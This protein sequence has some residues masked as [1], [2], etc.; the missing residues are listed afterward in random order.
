L[1]GASTSPNIEP[2]N[3]LL[4]TA[5]YFIGRD[6][7]KWRTG[8]RTYGKIEYSEVYPRTDLV[9][10][11][12]Q[13]RLE[14]D[15]IVAPG[16]DPKEIRL[17]FH[18]PGPLSIAKDGAVRVATREGP[19]EL[20]RP[21]IYQLDHGKRIPINGHFGLRN[22]KNTIGIQV[23][24]Y[25]HQK[26]LIIDPVL[27]YS[28]YLGG[29]GSDYDSGVVVDSQ[30]DAYIAGQTTS[31]NFPSPNG[32]A[33]SGNSNGVAFVSELNPTGTALLYSTYLGGTGGDWGADV[34]LDPSGNVY[35]TGST[36]SNDFPIINAVQS[37]LL[38]PNGNAFV[39]RFDTTQPGTAS[40]VYSTYL[41]GG[42]NPSTSLGEVGLGIA[43][44]ANGLA[45][46]TGQTASDSSLAPFPTTNNAVQSSLASVNGNAFLTVLDTTNGGPLSLIYSTYLGGASDGFG[47]YGLGITVDS[48]GNAYLTGQ[49]TSGGS[50]P[51]PTT[52]GAYQTSLNS[53]YGNVFVTEISTAQTS[54]GCLV[55]STYLGG[56]SAIIVGDVA[57]GIGLDSNK[58]IYVGG[59]TTSADFPVTAGAYQTMNS[60]AGKA[61]VAAFDPTQTG[62]NSLIYSTLLGGTNGGEGEVVNALVVDGTGDAFVAGSTSSS[63]F[64]TTSGALQIT[65]KNSSWDAFL[66]EINPTGTGLLYSTYFGGS[67]AD[68]DLGNGV[69]IDW[70]G[71]PYLAG[72]TCSTDLP[73]YPSNAYQ[74]SLAGAYNTFVAKLAF[75]PTPGIK[76]TVSPVPNSSGWNNSAVTVSFVCMPGGAPLQSCS[77]PVVISTEGANQVASGTVVDSVNATATATDAVNLDITP[78]VI[79][80]SS[81]A[82]GATVT[83]TSLTVSGTITDALSGANGLTCNGLP[84][85]ITGS[86][87]SCALTVSSAVNSITLVG[88]DLAGNMATAAISVSLVIPGGAALTGN[89]NAARQEHTATLLTN[90]TVLIAGGT[91]AN[92]V[93]QA[94]AELYN[95]GTGTFAATGSMTVPRINHTATLLNDG[96]VLITGGYDSNGIPLNSA[97]IY[98]PATAAFT[99]VA[100]MSTGRASHTATLLSDGTVLIAGGYDINFNALASAEL[101]DPA[102][103]T[104]TG[105]GN[106]ITGRVSHT[107]TLLNNG[108]VLLAGGEDSNFNALAAAELY[109]PSSRSFTATGALN[110]GRDLHTAT[111]L[112]N[113]MV[114]I[115][116]GQDTNYSLIA[117]AEVFDSG[118][119]TFT[120]AGSMVTPR[121][122][123]TAT[124]LG[125]GTVLVAGGTASNTSLASS[126]LY[127][128]IAQ[129][130][131]A[132]GALNTA[133]TNHSATLLN[134]GTLLLVGGF[135]S[136]G[137]F[138]PVLTSAEVYQPTSLAPTNLVSI[139]I[140]P[141]TPSIPAGTAQLLAATGTFSDNSTEVLSSAIWS[142]SDNTV[143]AVTNDWS[144]RGTAIGIAP[145]TTTVSACTGSICGSTTLTI[146]AAQL[147][148]TGL[149]PA[150]GDIGA[151]VII[152]GTG[153]GATQGSSTVTFSG[154][155]ATVSMWS[156]TGIVV[157]V[158]A[159]ATTGNV[160]VNVGGT[161]SNGVLFTVSSGPV[162]T[163]LSPTEGFA[164][165]TVSISGAN[166]GAGQGGSVVTFNGLPAA[167]GSWSS[168]TI[169]V[170][171]PSGATTGNLVVTVS[172]ATS[173][174]VL[175]TVPAIAELSP[176]SG[177]V[178]TLVTIGGSGFG[179]TQGSGSVSINSTPM[180]VLSW[181]DS[182]IVAS[183]ANG[184][185]SGAVSVQQGSMVIPGPTFTISSA[186]PYNAL[187]Q[188]SLLV[189]QSRTVPIMDSR[190][191]PV[192]GLQWRT[193]NPAIVS[194]STDNPPLLTGVA[195]GSATVYAGVV[196]ISVTVYAGSSLPNGTVLWSLPVSGS[197][198]SVVPAVPSSSGADVFV[199]ASDAEIL[200]AVT[201]DGTVAWQT[202]TNAE[203]VIPDFSGNG[204]LYHWGNYCGANCLTHTVGKLDP[205]THQES[206]LYTFSTEMDPQW[207]NLG[208][209]PTPVYTDRLGTEAVIPDTGGNLFIE[210]I[211]KVVVFNPT[212]Q[213]VASIPLET[214]TV[215][216][217]P[218][219]VFA[220]SNDNPACPADTAVTLSPVEGKMIVAGDGN[221]YVPYLYTDAANNTKLMLLRVSPDGSYAKILLNSY[222]SNLP[223][224]L[225]EAQSHA[226]TSPSP[227]SVITNADQGVAVFSPAAEQNGNM[228]NGQITYVSGDAI[229]A[230]I[231]LP[232]DPF[233]NGSYAFWPQLQRED[234]SYIGTIGE[235]FTGGQCSY[236]DFTCY[237]GVQE[238]LNDNT[239]TLAAVGPGGIVWEQQFSSPVLPLYATSDGGAIVTST[240]A[241]PAPETQ[242]NLPTQLGTL[243]TLDQNGNV[244]LQTPDTGA[245][246]SWT[247]NWYVDP[248][249]TVSAV[250]EPGLELSGFGAVAQGNLSKNSRTIGEIPLRVHKV[251]EANVNSS[252][253][254]KRLQSAVSFWAAQA[255]AISWDGSIDQV[256][257]CPPTD[258]NCLEN[259]PDSIYEVSTQSA[260]QNYVL[261]RF[262]HAT[263]IDV[264]FTLDLGTLSNEAATI[265][266]PSGSPFFSNVVVVQ[267]NADD[268][269]PHEFGHVFQL[270]HLGVNPFVSDRLM[271]GPTSPFSFFWIFTSCNPATSRAITADEVNT[272]RKNALTLVPKQ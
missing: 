24:Q 51:F 7:S 205:V 152:A 96:T 266:N 213:Q 269:L 200:S 224:W 258:S 268:V 98:N 180:Q 103:G 17:H 89:L 62:S 6:R 252:I 179:A 35:V 26:P 131:S 29:S 270:Q 243:Y 198:I 41:G 80:I 156:T 230:Q 57:S 254:T 194:L 228:V 40:L 72:S 117:G 25:D 3:Q 197:Y 16:A 37:S 260:A 190:D 23:A 34:A 139:S 143:A 165:T 18:A 50:S 112:D 21:E 115:A 106:L 76:A 124:L 187:P 13:G 223:T 259:D 55:Y 211:N 20:L 5:N 15:F 135:E 2:S 105:V 108:Q 138:D 87:F 227:L 137:S 10:Y 120:L 53:Q 235:F 154:T 95:P 116:G 88:T 126:E 168:T 134:D 234:G 256:D 264:V 233:A 182:V 67:C 92:F 176:Y 123:N 38:S 261:P 150:A 183:A 158:P 30:G 75:N 146:S 22:D 250:T 71:N 77:S 144:N 245:Q 70:L 166:F 86:N 149:S 163:G 27:S 47:D 193:T 171:V 56:S 133:R 219:T 247:G 155:P 74:T 170:T 125:N 267:K 122:D 191:N 196:P 100:N 63:D 199:L 101:Y 255:I 11:G 28:T 241:A 192:T 239:A 113:G 79:S 52:S 201:A 102:T 145:G 81:P 147:S 129:A 202:P 132:S 68:G 232:S 44:D 225:A 177:P 114:L 206:I 226:V 1:A 161:N 45:Y 130:F 244:A 214:S 142:A 9:Y 169:G 31:T 64:P 4:G 58:K 8:I 253:I 167:V 91:D 46:V 220:G 111:L 148:I 140:S 128:P 175:F 203:K 246:L 164:G 231:T 162:I 184:T 186:F 104:F 216:C 60:P 85:T 160:I 119:G 173:N 238:P 218:Q 153:F 32:Y 181:S 43:A 110:T 49:T 240:Q 215:T 97:E 208:S 248:P 121:V 90:R 236:T 59:D 127:D 94:S 82:N 188:I 204:Y 39:V 263:G 84:A 66:S 42:S 212:G 172:G 33:S 229:T 118:A 109:N 251:I 189:G 14:F 195:A 271:C 237:S 61:F 159:G 174:S 141:S 262:H 136:S 265:P 157:T 65:I 83:S 272:A 217:P 99:A 12:K 73:V 222:D 221:A 19:F 249:D 210:D 69:A 185:T 178:G 36:L 257:M 54:C 242:E 107:A 207:S 78:P 209:P 93:E 151:Q 48:S